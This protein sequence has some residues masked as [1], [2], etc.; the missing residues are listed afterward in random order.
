MG[1][2]PSMAPVRVSWSYRTPAHARSSSAIDAEFSGRP[3]GVLI[4][5]RGPPGAL[6]QLLLDVWLQRFRIRIRCCHPAPHLLQGRSHR[7]GNQPGLYRAIVA[8]MHQTAPG[9]ARGAVQREIHKAQS[10]LFEYRLRDPEDVLRREHL[11]ERAPGKPLSAEV[12]RARK[13]ALNDD[14]CESGDVV[15]V[16]HLKKIAAISWGEHGFRLSGPANPI[17]QPGGRIERP[18]DDLRAE[19][20]CSV[21]KGPTYDPFT[22][23]LEPAVHISDDLGDILRRG[24]DQASTLAD[25]AFTRIAVDTDCADKDVATDASLQFVCSRLGVD[26]RVSTDVNTRVPLLT[27]K[28]GQPRRSAIPIAAQTLD[29]GRQ[30]V[31]RQAPIESCD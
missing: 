2:M 9:S 20:R 18:D 22:R 15:D 13:I 25:R 14:S 24:V 29:L 8:H 4:G 19:D 1:G 3:S 27:M 28:F 5:S 31:W 12:V 10:C 21:A 26:R 30:V 7:S 23:H 6:D 17:R 11:D 16:D